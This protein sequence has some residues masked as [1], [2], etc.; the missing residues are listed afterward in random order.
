MIHTEE[1]ILVKIIKKYI[2]KMCVGDFVILSLLSPHDITGNI[3]WVFPNL[4][5]TILFHSM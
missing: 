1:L 2:M 3:L 4:Y 5:Y